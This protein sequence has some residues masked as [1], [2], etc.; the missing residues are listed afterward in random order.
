MS[1]LAPELINHG[2]PDVA[3]DLLSADGFPSLYTMARYGGTLWENW[4]NALGCDN[5]TTGCLHAKVQTS[6]VGVGSLNHIVSPP[7][8]TRKGRANAQRLCR[9]TAGPL[10]LPC[11]GLEELSH[12]LRRPAAA[13]VSR[14]FR[15]WK[16]RLADLPCGGLEQG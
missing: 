8:P 6:G 4:K 2:H 16:T 15:G 14:R 10:A 9:C 13:N 1:H 12:S 3:F 5:R 7:L 11:L